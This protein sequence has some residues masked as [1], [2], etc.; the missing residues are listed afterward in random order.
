MC[1]LT[2]W[3]S[4]ERELTLTLNGG[5]ETELR[6]IG[7]QQSQVRFPALTVPPGE[8]VL[9]LRSPQPLTPA[10]GGDPRMLGACVVELAIEVAK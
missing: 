9:V 3:S 10:G 4:G 8:S 2:G 7:A 1:A 6:R 5:P